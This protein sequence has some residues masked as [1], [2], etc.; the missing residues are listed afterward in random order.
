MAQTLYVTRR[1]IIIHPQF[2]NNE[3]VLIRALEI[4]RSIGPFESGLA[5]LDHRHI[6]AVGSLQRVVDQRRICRLGLPFVVGMKHLLREEVGYLFLHA[7]GTLYGILE[8]VFL[9][10]HKVIEC[11]PEIVTVLVQLMRCV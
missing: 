3:V 6:S 11:D 2:V 9:T 10:G 4:E 7:V 1:G 8:A 5:G